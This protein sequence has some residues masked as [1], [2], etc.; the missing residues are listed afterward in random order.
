MRCL[1]ALRVSTVVADG[2][3]A[4]AARLWTEAGL[5]ARLADCAE[6]AT[7]TWREMEAVACAGLRLA[8]AQGRFA[9][10]REL[11]DAVLELCCERDLVRTRG[12]VLALGMALEHAAGNAAGARAPSGGLPAALCRHRLRPAHGRG[13]RRRPRRARG[14]LEEDGTGAALAPAADAL[15]SALADVPVQRTDAVPALTARENEIL[16]RLEHWQDKEIAAALRLS[17]A[18]VRYHVS[19]L[20]R[21][22][23]VRGRFEAVHRAR[24]MGLLA[25]PAN[26]TA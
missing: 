26:D 14:T 2:R 23:G 4:D 9:E 10:G 17:A 16:A 19:S 22:L 25:E 12:R 24:S 3:P 7:Q 15:R 20:F 11:A 18:G 6:L 5:P 1:S 21:K 8:T 13:T